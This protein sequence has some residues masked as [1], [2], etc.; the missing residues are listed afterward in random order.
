MRVG[1]EAG[2]L[3]GTKRRRVCWVTSRCRSRAQ[4]VA[5]PLQLLNE[6]APDTATAEGLLHTHIDVAVRHVVMEEDA[7]ACHNGAIELQLPLASALTRG[8]RAPNF[9]E[10]R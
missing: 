8:H 6:I 7:A 3:Q 4:V 2:P 5:Q 1:E 10:R 9:L